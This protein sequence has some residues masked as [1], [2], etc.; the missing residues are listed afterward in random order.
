M[1]NKTTHLLILALSFISS[2]STY[3]RAEAP[4]VE[5]AKLTESP[6]ISWEGDEHKT[7][8]ALH[9]ASDVSIRLESCKDITITACELHSIELINCDRIAIRNCWVHNSPR[10]GVTMGG[11]RQITVEG[12]RIEQV[13]TGVYAVDAQQVRVIG[14]FFRNMQGPLPRGGAVQFDHV[15]GEANVIA[16]NYA[17]NERGSGH[18]E[19]IISIFKCEGTE[20]SPILIENNY[21]TGD[22]FAG[23][24]DK[25]KI[26]SSIMLGDCGGTHLLCR[27]NVAIS[28]AQM[29]IGVAGGTFIRVEDNLVFGARSNVSNNGMYV[30]N[31]SKLPSHHITLARNRVSW[32]N[33]NGEENS[34]WDGGG[35]EDVVMDHNQFADASL[36]DALPKP[37]S[38]APIPP[39]P[40]I[41]KNAGGRDVVRWPWKL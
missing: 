40:W 15:T 4:I 12:C 13:M 8:D 39:K 16:G 38:V 37:P 7:L 30:W 35:A 10:V 3:A 5:Q 32:V 22:P 31:Q 33:K 6:A 27:H 14:N 20:A 41:S 21:L 29:G 24:E 2:L 34:W 18:P 23:S 17:I 25:S 28:A 26:G 19:D 36:H 9:F 1:P 11:G